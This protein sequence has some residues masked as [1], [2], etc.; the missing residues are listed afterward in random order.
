[1]IFR[2]VPAGNFLMG[3][4][5]AKDRN[6]RDD[7]LPQHTVFLSEY[8]IGKHE[9]TNAQWA[10][11]AEATGRAFDKPSGKADHPVVNV[12]WEETD[13]FCKW[14]S[15]QTG[16]TVQLPT[17][18]QWEKAARGADGRIYPWGDVF[19]KSKANTADARKGNTT[20][21]G[22]FSPQ[23]DSSYK[24]TNMAGNV[25]EWCADWF[26]EKAYQGRDTN[27]V[28]NPVGPTSG[29]HRV[30]RG[31]SFIFDPDGARCAYRYRLR[32]DLRYDDVGFRVVVRS[33][34]VS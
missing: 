21:V 1:M 26:D 24:V 30:L 15:Q 13:A 18:A 7:E 10:A 20:P 11:F 9:V 2:R 27:L 17:E 8:Y 34:P 29:I 5:K 25:W 33:A 19:D 31:G 28:Q 32:P 12:S 4:D 16:Q 6:A 23:G 14:A 22:S 3:S